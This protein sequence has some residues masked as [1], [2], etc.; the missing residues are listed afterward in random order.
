MHN[1]YEEIDA[2]CTS[3]GNALRY[4]S[5]GGR[6]DRSQIALLQRGADEMMVWANAL[7][8]MLKLKRE[9]GITCKTRPETGL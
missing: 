6:V 7:D 5:A 1:V 3:I 9:E 2:A 4:M 8:V